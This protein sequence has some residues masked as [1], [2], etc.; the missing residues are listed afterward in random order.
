MCLVSQSVSRLGSVIACFASPMA[1]SNIACREASNSRFRLSLQVGRRYRLRSNAA[2]TLSS[3]DWPSSS[4][5]S[6][7][8]SRRRES[9]DKGERARLFRLGG[10]RT[11][12]GETSGETD[13][14]IH[15][16]V[17]CSCAGSDADGVRASGPVGAASCDRLR[18]SVVERSEDRPSDSSSRAMRSKTA[19]RR[20][21]VA[22]ALCSRQHLIPDYAERREER[23]RRLSHTH[24][25]SGT[26]AFGDAASNRSWQLRN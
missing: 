10:L 13:I 22:P 21:L 2:N 6:W 12:R 5:I 7:G 3:G 11:S 8:E 9:L 26:S 18:V 20:S 4:G 17:A 15:S 24:C 19:S 25:G 16:D 1:D 23:E 14:G